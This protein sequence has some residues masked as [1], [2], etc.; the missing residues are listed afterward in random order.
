MNSTWVGE[1]V[2]APNV[3]L[4]TTNAILG[5]AAGGWGPNATFR[6]PARG[7]TGGIWTAVADTLDKSKTRFGEHGAVIKVDADAKTIYLKDGK[8]LFF[9]YCDFC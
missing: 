3:K 7:G 4:V 8:Q 5:K 2:A 1:R 9:R 6:F